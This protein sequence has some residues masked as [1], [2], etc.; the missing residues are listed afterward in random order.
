MIAVGCDLNRH[1]YLIRIYTREDPSTE[2]L[3]PVISYGVQITDS[4]SFSYH[5]FNTIWKNDVDSMWIQYQM[6]SVIVKHCHK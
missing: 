2:I 4:M 1:E 6:P 5:G 3:I